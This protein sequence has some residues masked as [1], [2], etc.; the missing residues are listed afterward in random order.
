MLHLGEL[1]LLSNI[2]TQAAKAKEELRRIRQ[3]LERANRDAAATP[4]PYKPPRPP[5]EAEL[6]LQEEM[7]QKAHAADQR[8]KQWREFRGALLGICLWVA[9]FAVLYKLNH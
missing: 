6:Q 9:I 1:F 4:R 2:D 8:R 7:R 5:T 3:E